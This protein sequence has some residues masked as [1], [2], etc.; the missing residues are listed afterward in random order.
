MAT[1]KLRSASPCFLVD[2]VFS[3]AE[4]YRDVLGFGFDNF[5]GEPPG[6]VIVYRDDA[7]VMMKQSPAAAQPSAR[8]NAMASVGTADLFIN[9][10]DI[11]VLHEELKARGADI[12]TGP[13]HRPIYDG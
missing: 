2:D 12:L 1:A 8:P 7:R 13:V 11:N 3:S 4:Y 9:V 5:Y 6:F 10:D